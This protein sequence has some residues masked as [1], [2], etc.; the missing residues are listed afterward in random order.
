MPRHLSAEWIEALDA[1]LASSVF[2]PEVRLVVQ[3]VVDGD[4]YHVIVAGGSARVVAG[5]ATDPT[6][7]FTED[8]ATATEIAQGRLSAQRAFMSGRVTVRG[9]LPALAAAQDVLVELDRA[10]AP[11]REQTEF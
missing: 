2:P 9:D 4:S 8:R 6:V 5:R 10:F 7:T 11:V 1:S 3:H